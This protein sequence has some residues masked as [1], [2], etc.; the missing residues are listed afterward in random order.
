[1]LYSLAAFPGSSVVEQAAV[2]RPVS[3]SNPFWGANLLAPLK[4]DPAV[5]G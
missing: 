5:A 2:N 4:K 3:G 1:M